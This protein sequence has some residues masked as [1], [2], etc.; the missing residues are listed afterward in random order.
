MVCLCYSIWFLQI[1]NSNLQIPN[2]FK[3]QF[4]KQVSVSLQKLFVFI[5][6]FIETQHLALIAFLSEI[7]SMWVILVE[8]RQHLYTPP[9]ITVDISNTVASVVNKNNVY[10]N[11]AITNLFWAKSSH[12]PMSWTVLFVSGKF[13]TNPSNTPQGAISVHSLIT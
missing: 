7:L 13:T 12:L 11:C 10:R 3:L 6:Y 1:F 2:V 9:S 8:G 4:H 5:Y